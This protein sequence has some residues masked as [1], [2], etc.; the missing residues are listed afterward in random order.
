MSDILPTMELDSIALVDCIILPICW[1]TDVR[2]EEE[3]AIHRA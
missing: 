2:L 1:M 3:L